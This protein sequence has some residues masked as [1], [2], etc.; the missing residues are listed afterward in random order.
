MPPEVPG[1]ASIRGPV[2]AVVVPPKS[3]SQSA[4]SSGS[5]IHPP[6]TEAEQSLVHVVPQTIKLSKSSVNGKDAIAAILVMVE[7]RV[8]FP[9][10][11]SEE[12][13]VNALTR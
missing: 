8:S 12:T 1:T 10:I 5:C 9:E 6:V 4:S 11:A 3:M 7:T 2:P 13:A